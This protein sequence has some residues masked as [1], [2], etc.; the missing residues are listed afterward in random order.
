MIP[1]PDGDEITH[2]KKLLDYLAKLSQ[3]QAHRLSFADFM[4]AVLYAPGLG[5]YSAGSTKFGPAGD[6]ITAP[7]ISA[8]FSYCLAQQCA[9]VFQKLGSTQ[10]QSPVILELGA[11]SGKMAADLIDHLSHL[12]QLPQAYWILEVSADLRARQQALLQEHCPD[13]FPNIHWLDRLPAAP[14]E[15]VILGNEV[16]DA[17]PVHLFC[18]GEKGEYLEGQCVFSEDGWQLVFEPVLTAS[19]ILAIQQLEA[20]RGEKFP[21]GYTSE[22]NL[23]LAPW[24]QSLNDCLK[25]GLILLLDYG[26]P[27]HE[28]YH[29]DRRQGTLMCHYRHYAHSNPMTHI[30]RQDITAHVNFTA[31]AQAGL[32][33]DLTLTGYIHQGAFLIGSGLLNLAQDLTHTLTQDKLLALSREIQLLTQ[34]HEMGEL[35]KAIAFSKN[36]LVDLSGFSWRDDRNRLFL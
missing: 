8:L 6:F 31:V 4:Q 5:Y 24:I 21:S 35:F 29:P 3:D 22:I 13:Y 12:N 32:S 30:G 18:I 14:F 25:K 33:C 17:M 26:F 10:E 15:G 36:C 9:E 16:I 34:P 20:A 19:L 11:G 27:E 23:S 28:Y 2:Q 7:E 1:S